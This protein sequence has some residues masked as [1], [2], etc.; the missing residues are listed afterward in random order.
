[1]AAVSGAIV[2]H[3]LELTIAAGIQLVIVLLLVEMGWG[4]MWSALATT[5]WATLVRRWRH[6]HVGDVR[7]QLPF[8]RPGSPADRLARWLAEIQSWY[9]IVL[10]PAAGSALGAAAVGM[11][12]S[13]ALAGLGGRNLVLISLAALALME[14][15]VALDRG[16]GRPAPAWDAVL[17]L[18]LPWL[19]GHVAFKM[20]TWPSLALATAFSAALAGAGASRLRS[21]RLLWCGGQVAA[22]ATLVVRQ[23][24]VV[25]LLLALLLFPQ[26][27]LS[28]GGDGEEAETREWLGRVWPW[29]AVAMLLTAL[30]L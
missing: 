21:S 15:A 4:T 1:V 24:P 13:V 26:W 20:L 7:V 8:A 18:G 29:L 2:S 22:A 14:L 23:R 11:L 6:W 19:A 5:D 9:R 16:R 28:L 10:A 27:L 12:L 3:G 30:A 17:R 25:A